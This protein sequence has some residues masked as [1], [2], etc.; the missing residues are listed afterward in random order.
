MTDVVRPKRNV[1][2]H[3]TEF[4]LLL[5]AA[6]AVVV[7][8]TLIVTERLWVAIWPDAYPAADFNTFI[9]A[10]WLVWLVALKVGGAYDLLPAR[11]AAHFGGTIIRGFAVVAVLTLAAYFLTPFAFPRSLGL[12]ALGTVLVILSLWR[13]FA[14]GRLVTWDPLQR[15]LL[16]LGLDETT[17]RLASMLSD[18]RRQVPYEAVAFLTDEEGV[19]ERILGVPVIR[20][21]SSLWDHVRNLGINEIA[22]GRHEVISREAQA[23]LVECFYHGLAASDSATLYEELAG[24]MLIGQVRADWYSE[25]PTLPRRPYLAV[26]RALD[27]IGAAAALLVLSPLL[28]LVS[29][30]LLLDDGTPILFRQVRLGRRGEAFVVHKFRTMRRDAEREGPRYATAR[31]PRTTRVGAF[32]RP[33]GVDELPQL[34]DILRGKMSLIGPRPER[35]EFA[36]QLGRLIPLYRA[37][38]L[39][40]PGIVGWSEVHVIHAATLADHLR[41]LEY[42]LYYVKRASLALDINTAMRT[43]GLILSGRRW[44]SSGLEDADDWQTDSSTPI[45][46]G[47]KTVEQQRLQSLA[48]QRESEAS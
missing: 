35:P 18:A 42:D 1:A 23:S 12:V 44:R 32:L 20:G 4:V 17:R 8:S 3:W 15:R 33:S 39:L 41:R 30:A 36:E 6:D 16:L 11:N 31:D 48:G 46:V 45:R 34:W 43:M 24:R 26:K 5:A 22:V 19:P 10:T 14:G 7:L 38:L 28:L 29:I 13:L 37:R 25:L 27:V 21:T 2:L 40:R 9:F 47:G